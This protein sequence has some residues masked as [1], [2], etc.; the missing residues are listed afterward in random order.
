MNFESKI[1]AIKVEKHPNADRIELARVGDYYSIIQKDAMKTGD[2][3]AYIPEAAI[4]P[5]NIIADLNLEGRL[6]GKNKNRV[7]AIRLRGVVSQG[8]VY[9]VGQDGTLMG[10]KVT[11]GDDVTELLGLKKY[12]PPIPSS[13]DGE[14]ET[15]QGC[16]LNFD[17]ENIKKYPDTL[18]DGEQVVVTEKLHG[19]WVCFAFHEQVGRFFATSKGMSAKGLIFADT[20]KNRT[21]TIYTKLLEHHREAMTKWYE[22][23]KQKYDTPNIYLLGEIFGRGVQDLHY[24]EL[25]PRLR[26][27]DVF[28][29]KGTAENRKGYFLDWDDYEASVK[30]HFNMVPL[31]FE[32]AYD[33]A[34][35]S[36]WTGGKSLLDDK[37]VKEGCV[38]KPK[39]ERYDI[40]LGRVQLKS[41]S[42]DYLFRKGNATEYA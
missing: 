42:D 11:E 37:Q 41:V 34:Q 19:T 29:G 30:D 10:K 36:K 6:A 13:M 35:L 8:L 40:E 26:V 38:V 14:L 15:A 17:I 21:K 5:D 7:K 23:M 18:Q 28:I 22:Q 1:Y 32:G 31:I 25:N 27:F 24:A 39:K 20:E 4:V 9:P 12:E 2:L 16:T 33:K 3:A